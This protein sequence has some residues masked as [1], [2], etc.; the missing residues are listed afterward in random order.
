M[1]EN[2]KDILYIV[3]SFCIIWATF[4]LCWMFYYAGRVLKN[5]NKIIEEFRMRF[6]QLTEA[7][8]KVQEKVEG[9]TGLVKML[10]GGQ[11][12]A[13]CEDD[14]KEFVAGKVKDF[15]DIG[16][17]SLNTA[18]KE[19]VD[20]AAEAAAKKVQHISKKMKKQ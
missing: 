8:T 7:V 14:I 9:I 1:I 19:A 3:I 6:Q 5:F 11:K 18:A 4:F 10:F 20:K 17:A 16:T 12:K 15:V 13:T 2:S